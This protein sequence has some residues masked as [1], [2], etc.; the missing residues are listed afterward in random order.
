M[1]GEIVDLET[2]SSAGE[3][4][5]SF[6]STTR[7]EGSPRYNFVLRDD[8]T[9][10]TSIDVGTSPAGYA[11]RRAAWT[12]IVLGPSFRSVAWNT[13]RRSPVLQCG[14]SA[15]SSTVNSAP[16]RTTT[17]PVLAPCAG[18]TIPRVWPGGGEAKLFL[19]GRNGE[20]SVRLED[21]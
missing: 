6:W 13:L 11:R 8:R 2:M 19:E 1:V 20:L 15:F 14:P 10:R 3:F 21:G 7:Q 9:T 5:A 16:C 12:A 17:W 4:E 18:H